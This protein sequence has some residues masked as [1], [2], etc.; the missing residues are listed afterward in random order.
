MPTAAPANSTPRVK[1][2]DSF[3]ARC[4][5]AG[6]LTWTVRDGRVT[7]A[8]PSQFHE[9]LTTLFG[10]VGVAALLEPLVPTP[11]PEPAQLAPGWH[12]QH[13]PRPG[14]APRSA[15]TT[16]ICAVT[17]AFFEEKLFRVLCAGAGLADADV[18]AAL[19]P[20]LHA[21]DAAV[22]RCFRLLHA[23]HD[24]LA[25]ATRERGMIA[26]FSDR[27]AQA[28]EETN[29][30]FR[31]ARLLNFETDPLRQLH[32]TCAQLVEVLPFSWLAIRFFPDAHPAVA[33]DLGG[34]T[35]TA[36]P[37]PCAESVLEQLMDALIP[38]N[39]SDDWTK[40]LSPAQ[41][42]LAALTRQEVLAEPIAHDGRIVG[43]LVAG[44][45]RGPDPDI[46]SEEMQFLDGAADF[47]GAFHENV[48]RFTEQQALFM[49]TLRA[50]T[51][52]ID[53]K[54]PYTRGHSERV[55]HLAAQLAKAIG[56]PDKQV[57]LY[58][59]TGLIHDIGKIGVAEAVLRKP[60]R[61]TEEEFTQIKLHPEIG[62]RILKD[63]HALQD[64]L[65][66]VLHHHEKWD[67]RGYPHNLAGES[68]P[69]IARV[70]ALADSFDAMSSNRSYRTALTRDHVLTEITRC[71]GTQFDPALAPVFAAMDFAAFDALLVQH[72]QAAT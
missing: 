23:T 43:A 56:L 3:A 51:A 36:G 12:V 55:A 40:V 65:P 27:L 13:L 60:G 39:A 61:L 20:W 21:N 68:I 48:S 17:P 50:L 70:M 34:A 14:H 9:T 45:K 1:S 31:M 19:A 71:A 38:A 18:T 37:L 72:A 26:Q 4:A 41:S 67:G 25:R 59:V 58:R 66:G 29:L 22:E 30:M 7:F 42:P 33:G 62:H 63:V 64:A 32:A 44:N 57:E 49:G 8:P 69:L 52:S 2:I 54:D 16:L 6:V 46:S 10:S 24:D 53:A 47:L 15:G 28:F 11:S 5:A 35:I